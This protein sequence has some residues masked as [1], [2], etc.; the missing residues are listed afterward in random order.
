MTPEQRKSDT[1][2]I[3]LCQDCAKAIDAADPIFT[4]EFLQDWKKK[5]SEGMWQSIFDKV[6]FG[7]SM[8]PTVGEISARLQKAATDDLALFRRT[9][10]WP[11]TNV[12]LTL[13][14]RV[15]HV[16]EALSTRAFANAV[17]ML[18]DLILVSAPGMGKTTTLFQVAEEVT[19]IGN[20]TPLIVPL[21]DWPPKP[22][23][24]WYPS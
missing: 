19:E 4:E 2:G 22:A 23:H 10:K 20:C 6:A 7:P 9:P 16:D 8:P 12:S 17:T 13:T 11:G 1:N 14:L 3:W 15:K 18:D 5:H 24:C 21:G